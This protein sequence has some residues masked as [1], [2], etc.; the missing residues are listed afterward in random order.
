VPP[1]AGG[2]GFVPVENLVGRVDAILGSW[3][4]VVRHDPLWT[5]PPGLRLSRFFSRVK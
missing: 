1:S 5:W 3:D 4:P 2:V